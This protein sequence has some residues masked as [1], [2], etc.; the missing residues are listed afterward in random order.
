MLMS[1]TG[2]KFESSC[3]G[4]AR[5]KL[6]TTDPTSH[7]RGRPTSTN[8]KLSK[9]TQRENGKN[10]SRVPDGCLTLGRTVRL[11]VG[12][13]INLNLT[14][15][16]LGAVGGMKIFQLYLFPSLGA[17]R[18]GNQSERSF[19]DGQSSANLNTKADSVSEESRFCIL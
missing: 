13:K 19:R 3:A 2:L 16:K 7:Q 10:W 14:F 15:N 5:K 6:E 8:Q 17:P 4:D 9:N 11:T 12:R 1:P 18:M